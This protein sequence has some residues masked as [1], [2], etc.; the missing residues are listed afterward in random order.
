[1]HIRKLLHKTFKS[2]SKFT[3]KRNH[4]TLIEAVVTL[5][6]CKHLSIAALGR[7]LESKALIKNNIKRIDRLFA[8]N[9]VQTS[10]IHYYQKMTSLIIKNNKRPTITVDWSGLTPCGEF[11]F[12]RASCPVK[13]RAMTVFEKSY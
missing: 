1:M 13:G 5:S 8:N 10:A 4:K 12:L 6:H 3:D 7:N 11:N 9:N 2:T